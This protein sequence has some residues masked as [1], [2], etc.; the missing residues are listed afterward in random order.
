MIQGSKASKSQKEQLL[1]EFPEFRALIQNNPNITKEELLRL[2]NQQR[3]TQNY[4]VHQKQDLQKE[5]TQ[6]FFQTDLKA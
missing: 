2:K 1:D 3:I 4:Q 5:F 6:K